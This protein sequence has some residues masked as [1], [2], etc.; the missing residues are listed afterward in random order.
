MDFATLKS[1]LLALIGRAPADVCYELVTADIN[2][3]L[4]LQCMAATDTLTEAASIALP[5][6]FLAVIDIYRAT[7]P[8]VAL[9]PT[10]P[11]AIHSQYVS[12]GTPRFYAIVD[13]TLLLSPSPD[14][15]EDIELRYYAKLADLSAD[16]DTNDVLT[17]FPAI[18]IYGA[19]THHA[20]LIR[21]PDAAGQWRQSYS[22]A[23]RQA[24][25][26]DANDRVSG[27]PLIPRVA[28]TP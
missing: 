3:S 22:E 8:R 12:S 24:R 26:S 18:Y 13:G 1:R 25:G 5:A 10:T 21:D 19:L 6:D 7:D 23:I 2:R 20:Q 9:Q 15:S 17:N 16:G 14:G 4:R 27:A 11:Q 28:V